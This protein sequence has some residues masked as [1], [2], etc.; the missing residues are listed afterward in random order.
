MHAYIHTYIH[1]YMH[2]CIHT[3][4]HTCMHTYIQWSSKCPNYK[5]TSLNCCLLIMIGQGGGILINSLSFHKCPIFKIFIG[6]QGGNDCHS[7][8]V[9]CG[10]LP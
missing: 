4:I 6:G 2:A 8:Y 5:Q 3:Y 10:K 1:T 7:F 9:G